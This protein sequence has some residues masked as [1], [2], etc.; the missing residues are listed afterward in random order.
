MPRPTSA[1]DRVPRARSGCEGRAPSSARRGATAWA[2]PRGWRPDRG[3]CACPPSGYGARL[4]G[5][6]TEA[7]L[8]E[9]LAAE[10]RLASR[11]PLAEQSGHHLQVLP[12][13]NHWLPLPRTGPQARLSALLRPASRRASWPATMSSPPSRRSRSPVARPRKLVLPAPFGP[14]RATTC[15]GSARGSV[16]SR[17]TV[18]PKT[19]PDTT[20]FDRGCGHV[21]LLH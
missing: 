16:P 2:R 19:L 10:A 21:R 14:N 1:T 13:G 8:F 4:V 20:G 3:A 15:P 9:F 12:A 18:L 17:A 7:K 11:P 5:C 6:I